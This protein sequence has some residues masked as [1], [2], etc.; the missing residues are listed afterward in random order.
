MVFSIKD[1]WKEIEKKRR[2]ICGQKEEGAEHVLM[3]C[4]G[5]GIDKSIEMVFDEIGIL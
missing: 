4:E 1:Y 5:T 2:R 3:E